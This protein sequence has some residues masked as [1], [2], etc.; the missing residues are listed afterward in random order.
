MTQTTNRGRR[1]GRVPVGTRASK[2][3]L[4]HPGITIAAAAA[5]AVTPLSMLALAWAAE[6]TLLLDTDDRHLHLVG[7]VAR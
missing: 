2:A 5:L 4:G 7:V 6:S 1:A 3:V